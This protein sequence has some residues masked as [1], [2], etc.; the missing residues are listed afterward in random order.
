MRKTGQEVSVVMWLV[1]ESQPLSV[2]DCGGQKLTAISM[3]LENEE[4]KSL[5]FVM[6]CI[7]GRY[8]CTLLCI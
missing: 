7:S 2:S 1:K 4:N 5:V 8:S 3:N 6:Y